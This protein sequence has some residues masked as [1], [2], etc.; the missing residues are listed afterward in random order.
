MWILALDSECVDLTLY[1]W[2]LCFVIYDVRNKH[3][4]LMSHLYEYKYSFDDYIISCGNFLDFN[5][6]ID[7]K[8]IDE[9]FNL[10]LTIPN[11]VILKGEQELKF[12]HNFREIYNSAPVEYHNTLTE[13]YMYCNNMPILCKLSEKTYCSSIPV[14][15]VKVSEN[16][17]QN[18]NILIKSRREPFIFYNNNIPTH[19]EYDWDYTREVGT[20]F[21][22]PS[23]SVHF[24]S[25]GI[26][27]DSSVVVVYDNFKKT[28]TI[29]YK[30]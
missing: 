19:V 11:L 12:I 24:E 23:D 1:K 22:Y 2:S 15:H 13:L 28:Y 26:G 14:V 18:G 9:C 21:I 20:R 6:P 4:S 10:L 29:V 27:I 17:T 7:F 5:E 25:F 8:K 3:D 30:E 16:Y